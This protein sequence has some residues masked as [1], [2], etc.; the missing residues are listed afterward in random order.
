ML[1]ARRGGLLAVVGLVAMFGLAGCFGGGAAPD[2]SPSPTGSTSEVPGKS[3]EPAPIE[4]EAVIVFATIDPD[5]ATIS[6][7][8]YVA[9]VIENDG[10]CTYV[11]TGPG[12]EQRIESV[13]AADAGQTSCGV[14]QLDT[15]ALLTG[16]W[17]VTL[18]YAS[19][20]V[21]TTSAPTTLEI[22]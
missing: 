1:V 5:G 14:V 9:G 22:P 15:G 7:S 6:I 21:T 10:S 11:L 17:S 2:S 13:G 20:A 4:P 16:T 3:P 8:G 19:A 12:D 18:D